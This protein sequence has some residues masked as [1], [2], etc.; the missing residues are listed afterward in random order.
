MLL[1]EPIEIDGVSYPYLTTNMAV[2]SRHLPDGSMDASV[3]LRFIPTRIVDGVVTQN[4]AGAIS[5]FRGSLVE[6]RDQSEG[7]AM[8]AIKQ[9]IEALVSAKGI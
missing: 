9:A 8:L 7:L 4:D 5:I 2:T 6:L 1:A 3:A